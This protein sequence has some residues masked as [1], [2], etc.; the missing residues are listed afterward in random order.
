MSSHLLLRLSYR[1]IFTWALACA[2]NASFAT[3]AWADD[4]PDEEE[5]GEESEDDWGDESGD[6]FSF[7][8]NIDT[9]AIKANLEA[10][11]NQNYSLSLDGFIRSDAGL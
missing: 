7:G 11:S 3:S 4:E 9:D 10:K 1:A 2:V 8:D 5:W 6:E